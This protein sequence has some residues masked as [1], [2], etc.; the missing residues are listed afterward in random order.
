MKKTIALA[1]TLLALTGCTLLKDS[2]GRV[3]TAGTGIYQTYHVD[4][5]R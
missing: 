5:S 4:C 3:P 2:I 1:L